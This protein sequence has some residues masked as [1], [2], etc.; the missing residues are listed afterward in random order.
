MEMATALIVIGKLKAMFDTGKEL[1]SY[2]ED[3]LADILVELAGAEFSAASRALKDYQ[4][5]R[6]NRELEQLIT[7]LR[8]AYYIYNTA[9]TRIRG[10]LFGTGFVISKQQLV[11]ALRGRYVCASLI[12]V[13]YL[14]LGDVALM[15]EYAAML[16]T[17]FLEYYPEAYSHVSTYSWGADSR[18]NMEARVRAVNRE[19]FEVIVIL[20]S[21][22][23][24]A[25]EPKQFAPPDDPDN[26]YVPDYPGYDGNR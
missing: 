24:S 2:L 6:S 16:R 1:Y 25:W 15:R 9:V 23:V 26:S 21:L 4:I 7:H 3:N 10:G 11:D 22:G 18:S 19:E 17:D 8:S 14:K 5:S 12:A 20:Q 13:T